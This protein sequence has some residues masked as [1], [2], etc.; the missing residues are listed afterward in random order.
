MVRKHSFVLIPAVQAA[1]KACRGTPWIT[2][3]E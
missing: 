2:V 1:V 3:I